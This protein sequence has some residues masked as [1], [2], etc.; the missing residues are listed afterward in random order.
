MDWYRA[1][2]A[3]KDLAIEFGVHRTTVTHHLQRNRVPLRRRGLDDQQV[4]QA[5]HLYRQGS[6]LA[7][8]GTRLDVDAHT[9]RAALH[10]RGVPTR[11]T[12]GRDR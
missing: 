4:D 1:G 8:I 11:D 7:R 6:P 9:V 10:T 2:V 12:H 5:V 3:V